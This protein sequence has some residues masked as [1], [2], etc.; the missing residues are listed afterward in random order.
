M[1]YPGG[2]TTQV[3]TYISLIIEVRCGTYVGLS[4]NTGKVYITVTGC[5]TLTSNIF[6][7]IQCTQV[8]VTLCMHFTELY[9]LTIHAGNVVTYT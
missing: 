3:Y 6:R 1:Q 8:T 9:T 5:N 4:V 7:S 2:F